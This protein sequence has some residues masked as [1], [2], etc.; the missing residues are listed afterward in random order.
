MVEKGTDHLDDKWSSRHC[1]RVR[2]VGGG[3]AVNG[4]TEAAASAVPEPV[5]GPPLLCLLLLN[6][7][8]FTHN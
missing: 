4:H 1:Q 5:G 3:G 7:V 8:L 6:A 2:A